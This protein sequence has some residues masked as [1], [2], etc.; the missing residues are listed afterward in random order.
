MSMT[1]L[2][3]ATARRNVVER[4]TRFLDDLERDGREPG[5]WQGDQV[6]HALAALERG[7]YPA[8]EDAMMR[9]ERPDL[10]RSAILANR[11]AMLSE[12]PTLANL[13]A[14]LARL[15]ADD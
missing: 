12:V 4:I 2:A 8:G 9:A 5:H 13:R 15:Q 6:R 1:V 14:N 3:M 7:N 11:R 10:F